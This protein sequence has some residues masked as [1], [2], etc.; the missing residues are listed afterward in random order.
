MGQAICALEL[1]P[2]CLEKLLF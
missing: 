1:E 2:D